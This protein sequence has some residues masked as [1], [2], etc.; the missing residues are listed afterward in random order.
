MIEYVLLNNNTHELWE[1]DYTAG[2]ALDVSEVMKLD[3]MK[4]NVTRYSGTIEDF[5]IKE[6]GCRN[7]SFHDSMNLAA[8]V[9]LKDNRFGNH[10]CTFTPNKKKKPRE[11]AHEQH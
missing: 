9:R 4:H 1:I 3:S 11:Q 8:S 7:I 10:S 2:H 5:L 6:R